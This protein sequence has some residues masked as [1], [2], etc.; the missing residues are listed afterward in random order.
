[1]HLRKSF[2]GHL[3]LD[4]VTYFCNFSLGGKLLLNRIFLTKI[5]SFQSNYNLDLKSYLLNKG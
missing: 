5:G 2:T 1:M 4:N 3:F